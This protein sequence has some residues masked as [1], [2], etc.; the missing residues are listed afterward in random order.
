MKR[1]LNITGYSVHQLAN[2]K[3]FHVAF[4]FQ[5]EANWYNDNFSDNNGLDLYAKM[6][7]ILGEREQFWKDLYDCFQKVCPR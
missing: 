2:D 5:K 3:I 7:N 4:P 1:T 6:Y